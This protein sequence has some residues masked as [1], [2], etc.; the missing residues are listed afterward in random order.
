MEELFIEMEVTIYH[1]KNTPHMH[2][3]FKMIPEETKKILLEFTATSFSNAHEPKRE[4]HF[5]HPE[6]KL[7]DDAKMVLTSFQH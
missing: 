5:Q 2:D 7:Y 6:H 1:L 4:S 3:Q